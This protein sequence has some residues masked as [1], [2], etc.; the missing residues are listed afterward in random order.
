MYITN[1]ELADR[2]GARELAQVAS[3]EH[4]PVV[5]AAL[6]DATLR[7]VDR[8][9]WTPEQLAVAD[10]ALA[11]VVDAVNEAGAVID[12]YL[13]QRGYTLPLELPATSTGKSVLT[14]WA[15]AIARYM[16]HKSRIS[17]ESKD[18][19]A[20]DYRDALK[21]LGLLAIGK[22]SLGANDPASSGAAGA[23]TDV[24]FAGAPTVFGRDQ[25][26]AFR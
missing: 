17:D 2:P 20:R 10:A 8:S 19:I 22:Y 5:E 21:M 9:A 12:G 26:R 24:R 15:R 4:Q 7:G 3:P 11:R 13:A 18:P 14:S 16:L 6:L 1:A 25:L 23:G